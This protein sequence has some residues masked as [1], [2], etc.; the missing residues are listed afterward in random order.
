MPL[1]NAA[2]LH[3]TDDERDGYIAFR[4]RNYMQKGEDTPPSFYAD[5]TYI[6]NRLRAYF[7][8]KP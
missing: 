8:D 4:I 5:E 7:P 6:F 2:K 3:M 1:A